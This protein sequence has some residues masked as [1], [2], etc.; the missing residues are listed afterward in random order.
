MLLTGIVFSHHAPSPYSMWIRPGKNDQNTIWI[1]DGGWKQ[2][3]GLGGGGGSSVVITQGEGIEVTPTDSG[4]SIAV[5]SSVLSSISSNRSAIATLIEAMAK[6]PS[7]DDVVS[8]EYADQTYAKKDEIISPD[9]YLTKEEASRTYATKS[10]I[11]STDDF[12]TNESLT[13]TLGDYVKSEDLPDTSKFVTSDSLNQTLQDYAKSS[14][15]PD[16]SDFVSNEGLAQEL[17]PYAKTADIPTADELQREMK[18]KTINDESIIGEGNIEITSS[19]TVTV[20]DT[21]SSTSE[22]PVQNKVLTEAINKLNNEVFPLTL[23]VSGGSTYK[24]GTTQNITVRWTV[25]QGSDVVTPDTVTINDEPVEGTQKVFYDVTSDTTYTVKITYQGQEKTASTS[26]RFVA[27][28]YIAAVAK[29][30]TVSDDSV[31]ALLEVVKGSRSYTWTGNLNDQKICYAYPKSF[32]TLTSI[33]DSNNF[34][35]LSAYT[36]SELTIGTDDYYVYL[37]TDPTTQSGVKQVY[38]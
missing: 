2:V 8:K 20:D 29:D 28:S 27:P 38:S 3:T 35:N 12:V 21:L 22:N 6:Y 18:F 19:G 15:I 1:Y 14:E 37:L 9:G 17:Q 10:E 30:F 36:R 25:K 33:K 16:V 32:G 23:S 13:Q 34:E 7:P 11:P 24:K 26:A 4:Y 31:S 5:S